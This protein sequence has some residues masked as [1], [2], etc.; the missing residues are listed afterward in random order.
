MS[1]W[2]VSVTGSESEMRDLEIS[3]LGKPCLSAPL[4]RKMLLGESARP[5]GLWVSAPGSLVG[6][7]RRS[8][9]RLNGGRT[10]K[11]S[12]RAIDPAPTSSS[13]IPFI[14]APKGHH[15]FREAPGNDE[16]D[17]LKERTAR[18]GTSSGY[19]SLA[20][21]CVGRNRRDQ[22]LGMTVRHRPFH[23]DIGRPDLCSIVRIVQGC[24]APSLW[25]RRGRSLRTIPWSGRS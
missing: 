15:G 11:L 13:G 3:L 21:G 25:P 18:M 12:L 22:A 5:L 6:T 10:P 17:V 8:S 16:E 1:G 24:R 23:K 14:S 19:P 2:S 4:L 20:L 9:Y 7:Q